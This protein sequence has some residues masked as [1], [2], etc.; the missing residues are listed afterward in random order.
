MEDGN[1]TEAFD[2]FFY[3]TYLSDLKGFSAWQARRHYRRHGRREAR[4]ATPSDMLRR[5]QAELGGLPSDFSAD[6]MSA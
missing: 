6:A 4:P 3:S 5:L 1:R 2:A